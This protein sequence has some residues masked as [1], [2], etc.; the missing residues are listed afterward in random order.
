M[1]EGTSFLAD[2]EQLLRP[3]LGIRGTHLHVALIGFRV[4]DFGTPEA[5]DEW[6]EEQDRE[7]EIDRAIELQ[8]QVLQALAAL[9]I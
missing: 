4:R 8:E 9:H 6:Y 2:L 3:H 1:V 7:A 5:M